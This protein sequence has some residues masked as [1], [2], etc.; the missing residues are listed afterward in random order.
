MQT[1]KGGA[2]SGTETTPSRWDPP[3]GRDAEGRPKANYRVSRPFTPNDS[4]R[5]VSIDDRRAQKERQVAQERQQA[6]ASFEHAKKEN[7]PDFDRAAAEE[8]YLTYA[9]EGGRLSTPT[10][11]EEEMARL[12]KEHVSKIPRE[13]AAQA[14]RAVQEHREALRREKDRRGW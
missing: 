14:Y 13:V 7:G 10:P 8:Y 9:S 4:S 5:G 3:F 1:P 2:A 12:L 11:H 6:R